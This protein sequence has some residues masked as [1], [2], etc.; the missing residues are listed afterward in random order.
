VED[1]RVTIP[2]KRIEKMWKKEVKNCHAGP[3]WSRKV[4]PTRY[5]YWFTPERVSRNLKQKL[6]FF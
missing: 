6:P 2:S 3:V 4:C 5:L 1:G